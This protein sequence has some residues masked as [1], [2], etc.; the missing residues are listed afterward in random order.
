MS[1]GA[2]IEQIEAEQLKKDVP[3]FNV[4]DTI[5]VHIRIIEGEKERVQVFTGTVIAKKGS[6][7]SETFSMYR[8]A[9]GTRMERVFSLH[10]PRIAKIEVVRSGK[11][12][13]AKLYYLRGAAGKAAKVKEKIGV[14][15]EKISALIHEEA[16]PEVRDEAPSAPAA[17]EKATEKKEEPKKTD[18][19][20]KTEDDKKEE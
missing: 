14:K 19:P 18:E 5:K 1:Q 15:K 2:L 9:Y 7:L 16:P 6:G 10:S 17:E 3:P 11:V 20:K 12:R 13:R 8:I 4:G